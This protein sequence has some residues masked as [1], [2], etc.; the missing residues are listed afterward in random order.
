ME[1]PGLHEVSADLEC[2]DG[3]EDES[4]SGHD[5]KSY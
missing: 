1:Y 3:A 2:G 4:R 5:D